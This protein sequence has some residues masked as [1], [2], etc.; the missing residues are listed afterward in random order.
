VRTPS[1]VGRSGPLAIALVDAALLFLLHVRP[2][3]AEMP[4]LTADTPAVLGVVDVALVT[5]LVLNLLY[6]V[7]DPRWLTAVGTV[8]TTALGLAVMVRLWQV[9]PFD[10]AAGSGWSAAL[11][12]VLVVGI[13][14]AAIGLLVGLVILGR[15]LRTRGPV[16]RRPREDGALTGS[17]KA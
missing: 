6:L 9:F 2:G 10:V 12:T 5:G 1:A 4:F 13:A 7:R 14:G 17:R 3:W 16:A 15:V 8:V 11:R